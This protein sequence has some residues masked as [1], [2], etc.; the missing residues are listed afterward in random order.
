MTAIKRAPQDPEPDNLRR[1]T[2]ASDTPRRTDSG[3]PAA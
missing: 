2:R 1:A 3:D